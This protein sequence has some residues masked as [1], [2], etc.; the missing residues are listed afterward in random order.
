[1]FVSGVAT[2][3]AFYCIKAALRSDADLLQVEGTGTTR[4]VE[5]VI[6]QS[7]YSGVLHTA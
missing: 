4:I 5:R 2:H 3:Q 1:V 6:L 7:Q